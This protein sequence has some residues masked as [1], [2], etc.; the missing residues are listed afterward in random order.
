MIPF[1]GFLIEALFP[2]QIIVGSV[3]I[4]I[5]AAYAGAPLWLWS[6]GGLA[7]F[8]G[9]GLSIPA[10]AI[11]AGIFFILNVRPI[12]KSLITTPLVGFMKKIDLLPTISETEKVAL[13]AGTTWLDGE[14]FSGSPNFHRILNKE[15]YP[16]LN[17]REQA[18]LDGPVEE[19]CKMVDDW[20]IHTERHFSEEIW[21]FLK[22]EKFFGL[23]IPESYGGLGFSAL[24]HSAIIGKLSSRSMPVS[25]TVI[26]P[27]SLGPAE[28]LLHYGT[29]EQKDHYLPRLAQGEDIPCFGLTELQAGSDA[30]SLSSFGEVFRDSEG[31]LQIRLNWQKRYIT[32]AAVSTVVGLAFRLYDPDNLLGKGDDLGITCALIPSNRPGVRL[33]KRHDPLGIP[34]FNCPVDGRDVVIGIDEVIGG[35]AGVGNGWR[36]LMESLAAGR[37]VSLPAQATGCA[38]LCSRYIGDYATLRKQFG[39]SIGHFEGVQEHLARIFGFTYIMEAARVFTCG[40]VDQGGKPSVVSAIVKYRFTEMARV[41]V[42]DAMDVS[43]GAGISKGPRNLLAHVYQSAPIAITVEGSNILTRSMIIFGQGAIRCH[44]YAYAEVKALE[45]GDLAEFDRIFFQHLGLVVKNLVR[46]KV[47]SLSFGLLAGSGG[48]HYAGSYIRRIEWA[49]ANFAILSEFAMGVYG[50]RLKLKESI[51]GR[52]ADILSALYMATCVVKRFESEGGKASDKALFTW[53]MEHLLGEVQASFDALYGELEIPGLTWALR[54]PVRAWTRA[55]PIGKPVSHKLNASVVKACSKP[56]TRM[57]LA[58]GIFVPTD[59]EETLA[60][61]EKAL[62]LQVQAAPALANIKK[63]IRRKELPKR[64]A[65]LLVDMAVEKRI[66][67]EEEAKIVSEAESLRIECLKVDEFTLDDYLKLGG[68]ASAKDSSGAPSSGVA[69]SPSQDSAREAG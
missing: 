45:G 39:L 14:L 48:A 17:E 22:K 33:G 11:W 23:I 27:N 38:K 50:G 12:R 57:A 41:V 28:L 60:L 68:V 18:F 54:G 4:A 65:D 9:L 19:L 59:G 15:V 2:S 56:E 63:A 13:E 35:E 66:I 46:S 31:K 16:K 44:P 29:Q 30:G 26:V 58:K 49:S 34:F 67:S 42:N 7:L 52:F 3:A 64:R 21:N 5:V 53:S 20:K 36:M 55:F 61:F 32:L 10:L 8:F 6:V 51:T 69:R 47:H 25:T 62:T 40:A 43:G 37:S 24:A 1:H